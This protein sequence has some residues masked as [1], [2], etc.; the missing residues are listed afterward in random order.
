MSPSYSKRQ[1][2]TIVSMRRP[3]AGLELGGDVMAERPYEFISTDEDV[4][5]R[6][7]LRGS[8]VLRSPMLNRGTAF[9]HAEREA[10]GLTGLLPEGVSTI[11]GHLR[12]VYA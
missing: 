6:I 7:R 10:L 9:T 12:R 5:A 2:A 1:A 3:V 8:L 4:V 11:E